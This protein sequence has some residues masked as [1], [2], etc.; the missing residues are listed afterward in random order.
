MLNPEE[1]MRLMR[2]EYP[3]RLLA[4]GIGGSTTVWALV[5]GEGCVVDQLVK[6]S[7]GAEAMDAAALRVIRV[8][9]LE[10]PGEQ[11]EPGA[12]VW[13]EMTVTFTAN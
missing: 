5:T 1:V 6:I 13:I 2:R 3:P 4:A 10:W 9:R 12:A 8:A 11:L 7:S